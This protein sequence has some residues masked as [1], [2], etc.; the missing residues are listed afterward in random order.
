MNFFRVTLIDGRRSIINLDNVAA[1]TEDKI[2]GRLII[3]FIE[4]NDFINIEGSIDDFAIKIF[5]A[6]HKQTNTNE[7]Q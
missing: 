2:P 4:E 5:N 1:I 7:S 3:F 6:F